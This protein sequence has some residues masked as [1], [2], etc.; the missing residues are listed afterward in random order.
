MAFESLTALHEKTMNS[1]FTKNIPVQ[2]L[3]I[4]VDADNMIIPIFKCTKKSPAP[5]VPHLKLVTFPERKR[6]FPS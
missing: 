3:T 4:V 5:P 1:Y 2:F 6:N